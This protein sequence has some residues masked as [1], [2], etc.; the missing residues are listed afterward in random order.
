MRKVL[1]YIR[2]HCFTDTVVAVITVGVVVEVVINGVVVVY[3]WY[4]GI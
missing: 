2:D 3:I 1:T 4:S